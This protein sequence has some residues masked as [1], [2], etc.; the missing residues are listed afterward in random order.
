MN[1]MRLRRLSII[2]VQTLVLTKTPVN[3]FRARH[4]KIKFW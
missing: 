3:D 2:T 1:S 4:L